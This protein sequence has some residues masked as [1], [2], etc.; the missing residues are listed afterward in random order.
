LLASTEVW[1]TVGKVPDV[2]EIIKP[3]P[4]AL[5]VKAEPAVLVTMVVSAANIP[6]VAVG[7]KKIAPLPD[8]AT[9]SSAGWIVAETGIDRLLAPTAD[10]EI[11]PLYGPA[12]RPAGLTETDRLAGVVPDVGLTTI[13]ESEAWAV[14]GMP[15][16]PPIETDCGAEG[17]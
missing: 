16:A 14:N 2:G 13:Q 17:F 10:T 1:S 15:E 5:A 8:P 6:G 9:T 12:E 3:W 4:L 11:E 7:I